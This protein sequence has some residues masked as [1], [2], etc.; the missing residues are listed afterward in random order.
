[1]D[2]K[3]QEQAALISLIFPLIIFVGPFQAS[4]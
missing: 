3:Y 2:I 4:V 1:M